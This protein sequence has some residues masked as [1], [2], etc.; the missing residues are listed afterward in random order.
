[1][2][3]AVLLL[4]ALP[5]EAAARGNDIRK[6]TLLLIRHAHVDIGPP[7]GVLCG[8][9]DAPLSARG[10]SELE[11]LRMHIAPSP[12]PDALYTSTLARARETAVAFEGL[13]RLP[14]RPEDALREINCGSLEG[15]PLAELERDLPDLAARNRAQQDDEFAWPDGES[16]RAFR[17][18]VLDAL[19]RIAGYHPGGRVAVVTHA[20]VIAQVMGA[21]RGRPA[22]VWEK[23]RPDPL[24]M[25]E[26]AWANG[27]PEAVLAFNR[28]H[29]P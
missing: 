2:H 22:A 25:T 17:A 11:R 5:G 14:A 27:S 26:I 23:D 18:R 3:Q 13:W 28:R 24:T 10:H 8:W 20:G 15:M 12:A 7:P 21:L 6:T 1:M 9:F 19:R 29:W 4:R 16:Y